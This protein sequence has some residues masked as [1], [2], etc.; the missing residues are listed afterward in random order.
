MWPGDSFWGILTQK[1]R[2]DCEKTT[3]EHATK[4]VE[5]VGPE[6]FAVEESTNSHSLKSSHPQKQKKHKFMQ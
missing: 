2:E 1:N 3:T 4:P 6:Q 5:H